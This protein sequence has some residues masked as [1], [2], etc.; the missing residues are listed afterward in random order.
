MTNA[1]IKTMADINECEEEIGTCGENTTCT[2]LVGTPP[3]TCACLP[4]SEEA[5]SGD[6]YMVGCRGI[7]NLDT[8][9]LLNQ[10]RNCR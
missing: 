3:F 2:D 7:C 5:S 9:I 10:I 4:G 8:C 1:L 6:A